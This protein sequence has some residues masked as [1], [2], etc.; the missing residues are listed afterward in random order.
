MDS[1]AICVRLDNDL[2][3]DLLKLLSER[4]EQTGRIVSLSD[5]LRELLIQALTENKGIAERNVV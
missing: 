1:T 2:Y 3:A 5:V 4:I